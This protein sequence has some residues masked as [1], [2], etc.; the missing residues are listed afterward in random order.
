[1]TTEERLQKLE[2][3]VKWMDAHMKK[4]E[5]F[6]S[7]TRKRVTYLS[8][9]VEKIDMRLVNQEYSNPVVKKFK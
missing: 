6:G 2:E 7:D 4:L 9:N 3:N 5:S 8:N 1:M